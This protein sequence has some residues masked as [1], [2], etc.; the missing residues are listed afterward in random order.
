MTKSRLYIGT[1]S[2][3]SNSEF[4]PH[5]K[6]TFSFPCRLLLSHV[7]FSALHGELCAGYLELEERLV[8]LARHDY[9]KSFWLGEH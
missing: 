5:P 3:I 9:F 2:P 8:K 1:L 7:T 6:L 4:R